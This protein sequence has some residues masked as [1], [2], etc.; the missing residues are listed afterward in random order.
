[1]FQACT[2]LTSVSLYNCEQ[3]TGEAKETPHLQA[4][5]I[6]IESRLSTRTT[7]SLPV[8]VH[9]TIAALLLGLVACVHDHLVC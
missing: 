4:H 7:L 3:L 5:L 9:H 2:A 1:M 8:T 6:D